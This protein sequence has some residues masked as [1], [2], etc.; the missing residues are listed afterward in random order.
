MYELM[1]HYAAIPSFLQKIHIFDAN[2][3][4][5]PGQMGDWPKYRNWLV[6]N[7][8]HILNVISGDTKNHEKFEMM[9]QDI[10][11]DFPFTA[12]KGR[13]FTEYVSL[14]GQI[15]LI[16]FDG[17]KHHGDT[18]L[19]GFDY[20]MTIGTEFENSDKYKFKAGARSD[21]APLTDST[22][23]EVFHYS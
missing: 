21:L 15:H 17:D 22:V 18:V 5:I 14:N 23:P 20:A 2:Y 10:G 4:Y 6:E 8:K 16:K 11:K 1:R 9:K 13:G 19:D 7:P 12:K 3:N